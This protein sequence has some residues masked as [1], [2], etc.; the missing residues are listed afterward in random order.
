MTKD[1]SK[2]REEILGAVQNR[3][4]DVADAIG[5][6][7]EQDLEVLTRIIQRYDK[8]HPGILNYTVN[9]A[10]SEFKAGIYGDRLIRDGE[11]VVAR[12]VNATYVLELPVELGKAIEEVFP[13]MFRS[14]KHL[15]WFRNNFP[16][17]TISGN[18]A[19]WR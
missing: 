16:G 19:R 11:A 6:P 10:R 15:Q 1:N 7:D 13:S 9:T 3:K 5:M 17:L 8:T 12:G 4:G 14:K 18:K 2:F